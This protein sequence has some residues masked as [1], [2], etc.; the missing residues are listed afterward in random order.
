MGAAV[1]SEAGVRGR[2]GTSGPGTS[3]PQGGGAYVSVLQRARLLDATVG[4]V[5]E[6]GARQLTVRRVT[7]RAGVSS[8]T[9]YDLF[10]DREECLL[11]AFDRAV[12]Q[13][14]K[15]ARSACESEGEWAARI[16]RT[17]EALLVFVDGEPQLRRFV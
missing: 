10:A 16:R 8:K 4:L 7:V 3:G 14:A 15:V 9:F 17:L 5:C 1:A 2:K 6:F 13:L 11:A 12:E